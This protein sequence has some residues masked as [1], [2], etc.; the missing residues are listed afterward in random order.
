LW[1]IRSGTAIGKGKVWASC[2]ISASWNRMILGQWHTR[3]GKAIEKV[4]FGGVAFPSS[5]K[6]NGWT[7]KSPRSKLCSIRQRWTKFRRQR[8]SNYRWETA[9]RNWQFGRG[10]EA[11]IGIRDWTRSS[12]KPGSI[13]NVFITVLPLY[14][15]FRSLSI[16]GQS[17][18]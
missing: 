16:Q 8:S 3:M 5:R 12:S 9:R 14:F 6:W 7:V 18:W 11:T 10:I 4:Y 15:C 2:A 13:S 1:E 17:V